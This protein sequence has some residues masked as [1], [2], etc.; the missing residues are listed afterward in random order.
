M[1]GDQ[2]RGYAWWRAHGYDLNNEPITDWG[3]TAIGAL[4]RTHKEAIGPR[5]DFRKVAHSL[6][7][8]LHRCEFWKQRAERAEH[9]QK[10]DRA[11]LL[12]ATV[13]LIQW[14]ADRDS[15]ALERRAA[16]EALGLPPE[17]S[18]PE[19]VKALSAQY[20]LAVRARDNEAE[21]V[22]IQRLIIG[23]LRGALEG[24]LKATE[25]PERAEREHALERAIHA[26]RDFLEAPAG[27]ASG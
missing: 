20:Y 12:R 11:G 5:K 8:S 17:E 27:R 24:I 23:K 7:E 25:A 16:A 6:W 19:T 18:G 26:A 10:E 9:A 13:T 4:L 15:L 3:A 14:Q 21:T 1:T 22:E 2:E